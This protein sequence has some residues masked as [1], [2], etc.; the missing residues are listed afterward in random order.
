MA[1][2]Q[3]YIEKLKTLDIFRNYT[4]NEILNI[5]CH[6]HPL[7]LHSIKSS[8]IICIILTIV[9]ICVYTQVL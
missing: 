6:D 3:I 2:F 5:A 9:I 7:I 4:E 1:L 8:L